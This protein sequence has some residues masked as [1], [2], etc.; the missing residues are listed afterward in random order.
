M[1]QITP[2]GP[3][4]RG[5]IQAMAGVLAR[6]YGPRAGG[7]ARNFV[8]EHEVIGDHARAAIWDEV[9]AYL[10]QTAPPPTLS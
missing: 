6:R 7:I 10:E 2:S 9:C 4:T 1:I 3:P 5:E 8:L